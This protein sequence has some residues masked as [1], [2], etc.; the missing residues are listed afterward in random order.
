MTLGIAA[1]TIDCQN[2]ATLAAFWSAALDRPID[3]DSEES[4]ASFASIGRT[5]PTPGALA[6]MFIKVPEGKSA[7]NRVHLDL[8]AGDCAVEIDR[9]VGL[10]A[11]VVHDKHEWG[12]TWTTL[13]DPEGNEFCVA[14]H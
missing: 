9:L 10:G 6:M 8:N 14:N 1:I 12:I 4:G 2:A 3:P 7:K 13:T 11:T 5:V